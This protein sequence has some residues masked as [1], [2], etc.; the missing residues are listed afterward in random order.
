MGNIKHFAMMIVIVSVFMQIGKTILANSQY[1]KL[2]KIISAFFIMII[3]TLMIFPSINKVFVTENKNFKTSFVDS[4]TN[5]KNEFEKK[6]EQIIE[7]DIHNKF[8]VNYDIQVKT[9]F[10]KLKIYISNANRPNE[11]GIA[12]YIKKTYC[13]AKDE[14]IV[15]NEFE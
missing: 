14:V 8:Y 11:K 6:L 13:T 9:D 1:E 15:L 5:I 2:Y 7:N 10:K 12:E 3:I 4:D